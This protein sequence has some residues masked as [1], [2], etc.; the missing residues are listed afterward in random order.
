[1]EPHNLV[2]VY[3]APD[4]FKADLIK[5]M[6]EDEGIRAVTDSE[7]LFEGSLMADVKV[8]VEDTRAEEARQLIEER[9][10]QVIADSLADMEKG[11]EESDSE[12]ESEEPTPAP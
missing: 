1:M 3:L 2:P 6:L 9:E 5:N 7:N 4:A 12:P 10:D 8:L 11:D